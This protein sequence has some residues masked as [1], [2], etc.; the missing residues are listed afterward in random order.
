MGDYPTHG[1]HEGAARNFWKAPIPTKGDQIF[2]TTEFAGLRDELA[3]L[4]GAP[5]LLYGRGSLWVAF[6]PS[7]T[8][9]LMFWPVSAIARLTI[10]KMTFFADGQMAILCRVVAIKCG[11]RLGVSAVGAALAC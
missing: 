8:K 1:W 9:S 3:S 6:V 2:G 4:D 7:P 10:G 5:N 11:Q